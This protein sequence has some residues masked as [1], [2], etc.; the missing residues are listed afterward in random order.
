MGNNKVSNL[1]AKDHIRKNEKKEKFSPPITRLHLLFV[2]SSDRQLARLK[3]YQVN[4]EVVAFRNTLETH[5]NQ[6]LSHLK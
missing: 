4:L 3:I 2:L 6:T 5:N 1:V